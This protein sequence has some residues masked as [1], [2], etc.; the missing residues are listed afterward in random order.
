MQRR[1]KKQGLIQVI[2]SE[3]LAHTQ[4]LRLKDRTA[5]TFSS[6]NRYRHFLVPPDWE[7]SGSALENR[8]LPFV[9]LLRPAESAADHGE[10]VNAPQG[11][12]RDENALGGNGEI[13]RG[14][15]KAIR[16]NR[17]KIIGEK[18]VENSAVA[19]AHPHPQPA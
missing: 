13:G 7:E 4:I 15:R 9:G 8:D 3:V 16:L 2:C 6:E 5:K 10:D 12:S 17:K 14:D 19:E 1:R 11:G 18:A